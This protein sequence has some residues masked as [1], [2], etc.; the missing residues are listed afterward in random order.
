ML[1]ELLPSAPEVSVK[2]I[3]GK[4]FKLNGPAAIDPFALAEFQF[5]ADPKRPFLERPSVAQRPYSVR[6]VL[7][8]CVGLFD[9]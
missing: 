8:N 5:P 1:E 6:T 7:V 2:T 3:T 4:E 9:T